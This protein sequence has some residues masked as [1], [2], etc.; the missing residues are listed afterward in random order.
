MGRLLDT[1]III[2]ALN[3]EEWALEGLAQYEGRVMISALNLVE[4]K[5]GFGRLG[6]ANSVHQAALE[7]LLRE[8]PVLPFDR[9]AADAYGRLISTLGWLR[10]RD[11]D[12]MIAAHALSTRSI[13]VTR[14]VADFRDV[15]E[16]EIETWDKSA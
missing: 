14:N 7:L 15:P 4:V 11:F 9:A 10:S 1:N 12:R 13:L 6:E 5:R 16:L 2:Q 8:I 3:R